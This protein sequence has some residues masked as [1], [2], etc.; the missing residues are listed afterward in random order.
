M[1]ELEIE[2]D[3]AL[4]ALDSLPWGVV[5]VSNHGNRL[6]ANRRAEEILQAEDGLTAHG[7]TLRAI[8]PHEAAKFDRL[9]T[10]TLNGAR[11]GGM[12][13]I[14]RPLGSHPLNV[15]ILPLG[16]KPE[17]FGDR[18]HAAAIFVSDPHMRLPGNEQ[19][20]RELYALTAVEARLAACLSRGKSIEEA[21][22]AMGVTVNTAR[23]YLKR[24]FE[25]TGVHRQSALVR[26]LLLGVPPLSQGADKPTE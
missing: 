23:A 12:L 22:A 19:H 6:V 25:K 8:F 17:M 3:A 2:R 14:T 21:A 5:L 15:L 7:D 13:S 1:V 18:V 20:L 9:L 11:G 4:H 10:N 24:I 26:L 16:N